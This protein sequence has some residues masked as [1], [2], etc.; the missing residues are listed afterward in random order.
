MRID[1]T[2]RF[3]VLAIGGSS[4]RDLMAT[5]FHPSAL[6]RDGWEAISQGSLQTFCNVEGVNVATTQTWTRLGVLGNET[7]DCG[8]CDSFIGFGARYQVNDAYACGNLALWS[9]DH[10]HRRTPLFGYIMGR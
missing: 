1:N 8:S 4:L 9:P 7:N 5:G 2:T 10:G 3:A 6:G